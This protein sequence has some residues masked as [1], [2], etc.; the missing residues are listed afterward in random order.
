MASVKNM[1]SNEWVVH[2]AGED[3]SEV[4]VTVYMPLETAEKLAARETERIS[5][6][7]PGRTDL[8]VQ[9][10]AS[11]ILSLLGLEAART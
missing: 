5:A 8:P 6:L 3:K 10:V 11:A 9:T 1:G 7:N 2:L 4:S